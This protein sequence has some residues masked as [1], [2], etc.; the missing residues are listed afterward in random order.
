MVWASTGDL[1][2][3]V[4]IQGTKDHLLASNR[5]VINPTMAKEVS[6]LFD[7]SV[8]IGSRKNKTHNFWRIS[9]S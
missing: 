5:D 9:L 3:C 2:S 4:S 7:I 6:Q 1:Q 8:P